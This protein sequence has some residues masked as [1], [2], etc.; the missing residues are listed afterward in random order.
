MI[1][2]TVRPVVEAGGQGVGV[3]EAL[4]DGRIQRVGLEPV[5]L[6]LV[7]RL[8]TLTHAFVERSG[9]EASK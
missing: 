7:E 8:V 1:A 6:Q 9:M 5:R 2:W 4:T 3:D